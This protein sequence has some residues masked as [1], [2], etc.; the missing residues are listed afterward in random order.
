MTLIFVSKN[1]FKQ[2]EACQIL[3]PL[4]IELVADNSEI[5]EVQTVDTD[6]LVRD[7]AV[8]AIQKI[9]RPLFVEYLVFRFQ[10]QWENE[11]EPELRP[12]SYVFMGRPNP[13]QTTV[14]ASRGVETIEAETND[15]AESLADFLQSLRIAA[16]GMTSEPSP[17]QKKK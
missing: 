15:P 9:G 12:K 17:R 4:S 11:P 14:L 7:K 2:A 16:D 5:L 1:K 3:E 10:E 8:R 13:V 6:A